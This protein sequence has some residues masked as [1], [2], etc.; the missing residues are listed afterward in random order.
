MHPVR[1]VLGTVCDHCPVCN[2][3]RKHP[4]TLLG[5]YYEW[6]GKWCPAWQAQKEIAAAREATQK[7]EAEPE[8]GP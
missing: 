7:K 6:H 4:D 5:R 3:A 2:Y 1:K 8:A